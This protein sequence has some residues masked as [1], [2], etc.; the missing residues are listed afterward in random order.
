MID[1]YNDPKYQEF[2]NIITEEQ[3][4]MEI[5]INEWNLNKEEKEL[6]DWLRDFAKYIKAKNSKLYNEAVL[7]ADE[8]KEGCI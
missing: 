2:Q 5:E 3:Q 1:Y 6:L 4:K 7:Y 8:I